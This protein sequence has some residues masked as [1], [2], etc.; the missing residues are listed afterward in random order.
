M[1]WIKSVSR[2][3]YISKWHDY[4]NAEYLRRINNEDF[5]K[6]NPDKLLDDLEKYD[7]PIEKQKF[8]IR[9]IEKIPFVTITRKG[10]K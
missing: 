1:P 6:F 3:I 5:E 2:A 7:L 9:D 8:D 10:K 4:K